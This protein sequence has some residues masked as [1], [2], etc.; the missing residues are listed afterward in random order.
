MK[1]LI[2]VF[3]IF[4]STLLQ[5]QVNEELADGI[6][7]TGS[8]TESEWKVTVDMDKEIRFV[9]GNTHIVFR[10]PRV[11]EFFL[12]EKPKTIKMVGIGIFKPKPDG[13]IFTAKTKKA[14][15]KITAISNTESKEKKNIYTVKIKIKDLKKKKVK[16]YTGTGSYTADKRLEAAWLTKKINGEDFKQSKISQQNS[17]ISFSISGNSA[18]GIAGCN[19][20]SYKTEIRGSV[21]SFFGFTMTLMG[22]DNSEFETKFMT[23]LSGKDLVYKIE[24]DKLYLIEN[25]ITVIEFEKDNNKKKE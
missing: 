9:K 24:G 3:L 16:S 8:G 12:N 4:I 1:K 14:S 15:I 7:F 20:F 19:H 25:G 10:T 23:A 6:D 22:C 2:T 21:I 17:Y 18:G 5:A 11:K 13:W